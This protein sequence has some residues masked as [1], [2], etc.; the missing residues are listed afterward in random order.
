MHNKDPS[1]ELLL[2]VISNDNVR[3]QQVTRFI[4][5]TVDC[6]WLPS[7]VNIE[8]NSVHPQ[9]CTVNISY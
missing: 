4:S 8:F 3:F 5:L 1:V 7:N 2:I 6:V 9:V